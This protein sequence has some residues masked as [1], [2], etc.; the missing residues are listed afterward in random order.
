[1]KRGQMGCLL[2]PLLLC[3]L[4]AADDPSELLFRK[5]QSLLANLRNKVE[6]EGTAE[7]AGYNSFANWCG[8]EQGS[9]TEVISRAKADAEEQKAYAGQSDSTIADLRVSLER[10]AAQGTAKEKEIQDSRSQRDEE[11]KAFEVADMNLANTENSLNSAIDRLTGSSASDKQEDVQKLAAEVSFA[12]ASS[13]RRPKHIESAQSFFEAIVS[14]RAPPGTLRGLS[15]GQPT[16]HMSRVTQVITAV[17]D[18]IVTKR[19]T[20][21]EDEQR[22][23]SAFQLFQQDAENE[24]EMLNKAVEKT[25]ERIA[26]ERARKASALQAARDAEVLAEK[27]TAHLADVQVACK[28]KAEEWQTRC[29]TRTN[30]LNAIDEAVRI[31]KDG[32][33]T[34]MEQL[35]SNG[36]AA[37][38]LQLRQERGAPLPM[39]GR[40]RVARQPEAVRLGSIPLSLL[41]FARMDIGGHAVHTPRSLLAALQH[42]A[43]G[44]KD[45]FAKVK[46][47]V[48]EMLAKLLS[49]AAEEKAHKMWCDSET[50]HTEKQLR[51]FKRL[52]DKHTSS[53]DEMSTEIQS[54]GGSIKEKSQS[55]AALT[56]A[57]NDAQQV[58]NKEQ[59]EAESAIKNSKEAQRMLKQV[60]KVLS[61]FYARDAMQ[62]Q[63]ALLLQQQ[64]PG[65]KT[66]SDPFEG[67][68][69]RGRDRKGGAQR[70]LDML[71]IVVSDFAKSQREAEMNE[72]E[73]RD[74]YEQYVKDSQI[75]KAVLEKSLEHLTQEQTKLKSRISSVEADLTESNTQLQTLTKYA[76]GLGKSCGPQVT[77]YEQRQE[78]REDQIRGL[79]N[80]LAILRGEAIP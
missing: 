35:D 79:Q 76:E 2:V 66:T 74:E 43:A 26:E 68:E 49:E 59:E 12:V 48:E 16:E 39:L 19:D 41:Q 30:E 1:M 17:R 61:D 78:R 52:R 9:G 42:E 22:R 64:D 51:H 60:E 56:K 70:V 50:K 38:F 75:Q 29:K 62:R 5:V 53:E 36:T 67:K 71:E 3:T 27:T 7:S 65:S 24:R 47:M 57:M 63:K 11:A 54:T 20:L 73:A 69:E 15:D 33:F 10:L 13:N 28:E 46:E 21:R 72:A 8:E 44:S 55:L 14:G 23:H 31:L 58:R 37:S 77:N 32:G 18:D 40:I 4:A 34:S 25:R 45:P 80:A 6:S